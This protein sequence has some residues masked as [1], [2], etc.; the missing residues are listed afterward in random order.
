MKR[1]FLLAA[2]AIS[3][4]TTCLANGK[5]KV[6]AHRGFWATEGSPQN[7]IRALVK[8]DSIGCWGSEFDVW[9]TQ[10]GKLVVN[11]DDN[12]NGIVIETSTSK[13]VTAQ[14]LANGEHV[15]YLS[16]YLDA[17]RK[18][19]N[20]KVVCE[21]KAHKDK[22]V[23]RKAVHQILKMMK[24][25]GL[26]NRAVYISFSL[27]ATK[28]F[29]KYAPKGT[30]VYYLNGEL[31]PAELKAI[32]CAGPDYHLNCFHKNPNWIKECHDLGLKVNIWTVNKKED[33]QW[34]IDNGADFITTN[35]P[36]LL[37]ELLK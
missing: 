22:E 23:E 28:E 16:A 4:A 13:E 34:C 19:P 3:M 15:P 6:V 32:G 24:K 36:L 27:Q 7:S 5:A 2:L 12:I 30:E 17:F 33:L 29:I 8:A 37:Q 14:K 20:L 21:L 11:H 26:T 31:S 25:K 1:I 35:D 9:M 10:D 18:H